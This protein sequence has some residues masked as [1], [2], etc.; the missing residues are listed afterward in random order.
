MRAEREGR[1]GAVVLYDG[2]CG[3][4]SRTV[5]FILDHERTHTLRFASLDSP[6]AMTVLSARPELRDVDSLVW[7]DGETA[8]VRSSGALRVARY[9]G[10]PWRLAAMLQLVPIPLRDWV[11]DVVARHRHRIAGHACFVPTP[12]ERSRFLD[13]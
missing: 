1:Q 8:L 4:C 5:R 6:Y 7:V 11:Y 9:L 10:G 12:A 13:G 2:A 3:F